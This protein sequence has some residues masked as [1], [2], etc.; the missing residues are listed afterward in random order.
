MDMDSIFK[1]IGSILLFV[2]F[3]LV[4]FIYYPVFFE[5]VRYQTQV[6]RPSEEKEIVPI[7]KEFGLVIPKIGINVKVFANVNPRDPKEY[8][9]ILTKGVA[10]A[11]ESVF[12]GDEGNQRHPIQHHSL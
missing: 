6:I 7:S 1:I 9:P 4:G 10:H 5:E 11:A 8:L 2:G 12:P 3:V